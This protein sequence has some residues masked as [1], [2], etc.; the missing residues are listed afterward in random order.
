MK[1]T[2]ESEGTL[3]ELLKSHVGYSSNTKVRNIIKSGQVMVSGQ[4]I[5]IPSTGLTKGQVVELVAA[6]NSGKRGG[7][8][9]PVLR[10]EII[11]EDENLL[12]VNKKVGLISKSS[13]RK[14]KTL[15]SDVL[16]YFRT[17]GEET[18]LM[19]NK[20]D[21]QESGLA[22]FAKN[23]KVFN[24][25]S[26]DWKSVQKRHYVTIPGGMVDNEGDLEDTF[27]V[28]DIGLLLPGKGKRT[29]EVELNYRVMKSNGQFSVIRVE[30]ISQHKNQ[31][32]AMFSSLQNPIVGDKK[33]RS[34][35]PFEKGIA[36]HLFSLKMPYKGD[37][38]E[39]KTPI[40]KSFLKLAR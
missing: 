6:E 32:R 4:V 23:L 17:K 38:L 22:V 14:L 39:L 10:H 20:V 35:Y 18:C 11:F 25:L 3:L 16:N 9:E 7:S 30:E 24:E 5:K 28:N 15:Y 26:E 40:P 1:F 36:S 31:I 33:Y 19:V 13:N 29:V 21:K 8:Q 37:W 27:H 12:V 2:T 34:K